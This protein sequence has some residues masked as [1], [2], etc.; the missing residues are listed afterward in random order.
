[1]FRKNFL[2]QFVKLF[3]YISLRDETVSDGSTPCGRP[4]KRQEEGFF[5][6]R[7]YSRIQGKS[8]VSDTKI[9]SLETKTSTL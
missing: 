2:N 3:V 4:P 5:S 1:M 9:F 8:R 6:N 7:I